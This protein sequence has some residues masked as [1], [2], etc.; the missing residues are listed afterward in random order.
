MEGIFIRDKKNVCKDFNNGISYVLA[1]FLCVVIL[2][3]GQW[4]IGSTL[5]NFTHLTDSLEIKV[6]CETNDNA[7]V[8]DLSNGHRWFL[9]DR[10]YVWSERVWGCGFEGPAQC[11][12]AVEVHKRLSAT[13]TDKGRDHT[14][15]QRWARS[16]L[17]WYPSIRLAISV[18]TFPLND[19]NEVKTEITFRHLKG[20]GP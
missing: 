5:L 9:E 6:R 12:T 4:T 11:Q 7:G 2:R 1:W 13:G 10:G 16:L 8:S 3:F 18:V 20:F 14:I 15:A 17:V 19:E